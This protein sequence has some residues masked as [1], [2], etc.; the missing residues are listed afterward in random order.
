MRCKHEQQL[1]KFYKLAHI[2]FHFL[3]PITT[4][5]PL[6]TPTNYML[7][8]LTGFLEMVLSWYVWIKTTILSQE[9]YFPFTFPKWN[10]NTLPFIENIIISNTHVIKILL[11]QLVHSTNSQVNSPNL[12]R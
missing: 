2:I 1:F 9:K 6:D 5:F 3:C 7:L 8:S 10:E 11:S 4:V 12:N